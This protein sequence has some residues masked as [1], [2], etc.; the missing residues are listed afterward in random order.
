MI[1]TVHG[2]PDRSAF[3]SKNYDDGKA[4]QWGKAHGGFGGPP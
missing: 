1:V 3:D 2:W 4:M